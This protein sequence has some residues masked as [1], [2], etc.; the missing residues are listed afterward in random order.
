MVVK[1]IKSLPLPDIDPWSFNPQ[2]R[3]YTDYAIIKMFI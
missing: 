1:N 2:P 3:N